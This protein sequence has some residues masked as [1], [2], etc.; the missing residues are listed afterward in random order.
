MSAPV[1]HCIFHAW[2][3][4]GIVVDPAPDADGDVILKHVGDVQFRP[5]LVQAVIPTDVPAEDAARMLR[6][7]ARWIE[8]QSTRNTADKEVTP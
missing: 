7:I 6:K 1:A 4:S 2:Q 5:G 3:S 8:L